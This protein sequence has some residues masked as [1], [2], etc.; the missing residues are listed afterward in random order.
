MTDEAAAYDAVDAQLLSC[1]VTLQLLR[2]EVGNK[3]LMATTLADFLAAVAGL[4]PTLRTLASATPAVEP[5][6][7]QAA[8]SGADDAPCPTVRR[9]PRKPPQYFSASGAGA[10]DQ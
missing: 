5:L 2:V 1:H 6:A 10:P 9:V 3:A 4:E 7:D 8:L